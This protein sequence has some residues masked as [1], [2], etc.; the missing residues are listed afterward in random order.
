ML[1]FILLVSSHQQQFINIHQSLSISYLH[2]NNIVHTNV[3]QLFSF[4]WAIK[5]LAGLDSELFLKCELE[6]TGDLCIRHLYKSLRYTAFNGRPS[7]GELR[8]PITK[9]FLQ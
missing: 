3:H 9:Y 4:M 5:Y 6:K 1:N 8:L 2:F 7:E